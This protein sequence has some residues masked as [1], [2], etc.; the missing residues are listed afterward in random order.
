MKHILAAPQHELLEQLAWSD[1][2]LG[3]DFDGTLAP[4][5][6]DPDRATMRAG[7]SRRLAEVARL[8]PCVVISGRAV[9]DLRPRLPGV[10]LRGLVG[11]HGIEPWRATEDLR[12]TV[13]RWRVELGRVLGPI[14]GVRIEDKQY[15]L[16]LHY[17]S[18]RGKKRARSAIM[19]ALADLDDARV[20][21]GKLVVNVLPLGAPHK[22][23]ALERERDRLGCDTALFVG[24][25]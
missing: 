13:E 23:V 9:A 11:N 3:F 22:G 25:D 24:D 19:L 12:R 10:A 15:S 5:V 6:S 17:R 7:T 16:A 4:I 8:Y 14:E 1:V 2:L 20:I 18:S 21:G